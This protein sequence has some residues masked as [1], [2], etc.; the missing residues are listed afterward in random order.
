MTTHS[1]VGRAWLVMAVQ[2]A[3]SRLSVAQ[4]RQ[5]ARASFSHA[6]SGVDLIVGSRASPT[7]LMLYS[8]FHLGRLSGKP[9]R[10]DVVFGVSSWSSNSQYVLRSVRRDRS[11]APGEVGGTA[12][13]GGQLSRL[14]SSG[15]DEH[16]F[17]TWCVG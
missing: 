16:V 5:D 12:S 9:N 3:W 15:Y 11:I 8:V 1:S 6:V 14:S 10:I 2:S 4:L 7:E 17:F 13:D